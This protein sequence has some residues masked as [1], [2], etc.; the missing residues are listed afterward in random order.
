MVSL[1]QQYITK[2]YLIENLKRHQKILESFRKHEL[3]Q[4]SRDQPQTTRTI[5]KDSSKT[6]DKNWE[7]NNIHPKDILQLCL[8][9]LGV[10]SDVML[11]EKR[12]RFNQ[13]LK[14]MDKPGQVKVYDIID[15]YN[16]WINLSI[17]A[18]NSG[19]LNMS[20]K[21]ESDD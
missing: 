4:Q 21:S 16:Y 9:K 15:N 14:L 2:E 3:V 1:S 5:T 10:V 6:Q 8:L 12:N 13:L 11:S 7:Q 18:K 17:N 20:V 19:M